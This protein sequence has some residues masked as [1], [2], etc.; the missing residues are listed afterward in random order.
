M[1]FSKKNNYCTLS[2]QG[3]TA[4]EMMVTVAI[5]GMLAAIAL[6]SYSA[7]M[8][9]YR[10]SSENTSLM[11]DF[12]LARGEAVSRSTR[13]TVCQSSDGLTCA[14]D[15]WGAGRIVFAD[16]TPAGVVDSGDVILRAT[17]AIASGD[18]MTP[19]DL[20]FVSYDSTGVSSNNFTITTCKSG[21]TGAKVIVYPTGRIRK[22]TSGLCP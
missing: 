8:A 9:K 10:L 14:R 4:V 18:L 6:P 3:F 11:L 17:G 5:I 2:C 12:V 20:P 7:L 13:V 1:S 15:G 22:D 19:N 21:Y 16:A